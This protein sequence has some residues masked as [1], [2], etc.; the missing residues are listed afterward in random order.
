[1]VLLRAFLL[2]DREGPNCS[3]MVLHLLHVERPIR[4]RLI[5]IFVGGNG[6]FCAE[7]VKLG[8]FLL[9]ERLLVHL[10]SIP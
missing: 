7:R 8:N 3:T 6:M 10:N 5:G 1:M 9:R 4:R 2:I